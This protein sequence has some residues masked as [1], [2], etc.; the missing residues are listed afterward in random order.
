MNAAY[1]TRL[2]PKDMHGRAITMIMSGN[3]MGISVGLSLMT[4][5]GIT[6]GWQSAF[7]VL[8]LIVM[9]IGVLVHFYLPS[10]KGESKSNSP[11]TIIRMPVILIVLL[12]TFLSV[13]AHSA[14]CIGGMVLEGF[15][16]KWPEPSFDV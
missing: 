16:F 7:V 13:M 2:V 6:F 8:G 11:F 5:I 9:A 3:T 4:T 1:G 15:L 12:L 10:V 14:T